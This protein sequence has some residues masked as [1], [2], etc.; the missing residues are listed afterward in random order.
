MK[1]SNGYGCA[2]AAT[3]S[4]WC[5][6]SVTFCGPTFRCWWKHKLLGGGNYS[7]VELTYISLIT[8]T[9][10]LL[11]GIT[12]SSS[13]I[14]FTVCLLVWVSGCT[15]C[16][17]T[18]SKYDLNL[19]LNLVSWILDFLTN[20]SQRVRVNGF[21]SDQVSSSTG[22]PQGCVLSP[23]FCILYKYVS[24]QFS[25]LSLLTHSVSVSKVLFVQN[26]LS[27]ELKS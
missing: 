21:L 9:G 25:A 4:S 11:R 17:L 16:T 7:P 5:V 3:S 27:E 1:T 24:E 10:K 15:D 13:V 12:L 14:A 6:G 20:R 23:L 2:K 18:A 19:S 8:S 26:R 22:S